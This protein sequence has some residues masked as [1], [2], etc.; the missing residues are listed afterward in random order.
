MIS[1]EKVTLAKT[2][3]TQR[4]WYK[5]FVHAS[6]YKVTEI[7]EKGKFSYFYRRVKRQEHESTINCP[8]SYKTRIK[9]GYAVPPPP[10]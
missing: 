6:P 3:H 5:G 7:L 10:G 2:A 8:P 1:W 4:Q 9:D